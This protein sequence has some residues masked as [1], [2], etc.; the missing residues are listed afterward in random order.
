M[1]CLFYTPLKET[2][3]STF[4]FALEESLPTEVSVL[5]EI[6]MRPEYEALIIK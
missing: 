5:A 1:I 2:L 6:E 4:W 3:A